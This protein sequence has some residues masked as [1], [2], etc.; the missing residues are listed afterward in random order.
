MWYGVYLGVISLSKG[1]EEEMVFCCVREVPVEC[2]VEVHMSAQGR[3]MSPGGPGAV[4]KFSGVVLD[5][6]TEDVAQF[7]ALCL[8]KKVN[9]F[10]SLLLL[11]R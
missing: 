6:A 5:S 1:E 10:L 8:H 7:P 2:S 4:S 11:Y 9:I 3:V